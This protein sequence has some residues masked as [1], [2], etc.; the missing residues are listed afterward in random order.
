[1]GIRP[2]DTDIG[3]QKQQRQL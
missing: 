1:M 2:S 3:W